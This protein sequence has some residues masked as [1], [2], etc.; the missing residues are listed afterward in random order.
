[1]KK[2]DKDLLIQEINQGAPKEHEAI[3]LHTQSHSTLVTRVECSCGNYHPISNNSEV[4]WGLNLNVKP[5]TRSQ[6]NDD[7]L[8]SWC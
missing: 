7:P 4:G 2:E 3:R 8:G 6:N 5:I 1:M